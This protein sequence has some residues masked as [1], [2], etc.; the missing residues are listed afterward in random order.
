[1]YEG[2][3]SC[4]RADGKLSDFFQCTAGVRQGENLSPIL[5]AIYLND[6]QAFIADHSAGLKDFESAMEEFSTFAKLCVL[7]YADDTVLLAES[8]DELQAALDALAAYCKLW[9]LT[10]NLS[11]TNVVI[12]SKGKIT[13]KMP[14]SGKFIFEGKEVKVVDDYTY[15]GVIF[16]FNGSFK[17]AIANQKAVAL[18]AMQALLTKVRLLILDVDT[19]LELFQRCVMPIL[20]YG[21]EIW[22]YDIGH[23]AELDVLYKGFI[24]QILHVYGA[25][26]TCMVFGESGQPDLNSLISTRQVGFWAKLA[27]DATPRLSK[28]IL[29]VVTGLQGKPTPMHGSGRESHFDFKWLS[30]L[31]RTLNELGLGYMFDQTIADPKFIL[32]EVKKRMKDSRTQIWQGE[33]REHLECVNYRMFKNEW[34]L[35]PYLVLLPLGQRTLITKFRTRN[36]NLPVCPNSH[37]K[38]KTDDGKGEAKK[39]MALHCPLCR[40]NEIGDEYHYIFKCPAFA[41]DRKKLIDTRFTSRPN[42]LKFQELFES[43]DIEVLSKLSKFT[44]SIMSNFAAEKPWSPLRVK[45]SYTLRSGRVTKRPPKL[46]DFFV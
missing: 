27:H 13:T 11:K 23:I 28:L 2:A 19:S 16:N 8:A 37:F 15:L 5:F 46:K 39:G 9:D 43:S 29:P 33:I 14:K 7:L 42:A 1:M 17:K 24:K 21:S 38:R 22:A 45:E 30:H 31:R 12:F 18:R 44:N 40:L 20:M 4:V 26:P 10:V 41:S 25:T 32:L 36:H 3:K 6:F 35:S 34:G